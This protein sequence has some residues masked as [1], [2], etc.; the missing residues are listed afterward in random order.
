MAAKKVPLEKLSEA[1]TGILDEY[2]ED[3]QGNLTTITRKFGQKGATALR[4]QSKLTFKTHSGDYAKGWKYEYRK[5]KRFQGTTI[6]NEHYSRPH[7]LENDHVIR[8]GTKRV[9]GNYQGRPHIAPIANELTEQYA[10]E[11]IS[12]L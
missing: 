11:V 1:I 8:N 12:K 2:C 6:F 3:V 5:T 4:Q 7:L 10:E 9:V